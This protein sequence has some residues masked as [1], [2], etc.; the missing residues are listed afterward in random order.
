MQCSN[1]VTPLSKAQGSAFLDNAGA[2]TAILVSSMSLTASGLSFRA[3]GK[4]H[5]ALPFLRQRDLAQEIR[6]V[7]CTQAQFNHQEARKQDT[8]AGAVVYALPPERTDVVSSLGAGTTS[9]S[10]PLDEPGTHHSH[11]PLSIAV[12]VKN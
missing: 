6:S 8:E 7:G 12:C 5:P 4:L 11:D 3:V 2:Q 9:T 1:L 10:N